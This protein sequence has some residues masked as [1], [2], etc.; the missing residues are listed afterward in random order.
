MTHAFRPWMSVLVFAVTL[1]GVEAP[2]FAQNVAA[3]PP[4]FVGKIWVAT[5]PEAAPGTLRIF[6]AD[7]ALLMTSCTETYRV[8]RGT[9]SGSRVRWQE[10]SERIDAQVSGGIRDLTLTLALRGGP[11]VEHYRL[12]TSPLLCGD[13]R[14]A[15]DPSAWTIVANTGAPPTLTGLTGTVHHLDIEGGTW[16]IR[17]AAG[18]QFNPMNL[19]VA[20]RVE[21]LAVEL[22]AR[23]R[24]DLVSIAMTGPLLQIVRIRRRP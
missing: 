23:R 13:L 3:N 19:P 21:G 10:D 12:A 24:D 9:R 7:G 16:V 14:P 5:D 17:D 6:T 8:A 20:F 2:A 15:P 11:K 18:T 22:D 4:A 1:A